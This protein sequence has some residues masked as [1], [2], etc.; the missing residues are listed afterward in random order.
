MDDPRWL[1]CDV[2]VHEDHNRARNIVVARHR[3]AVSAGRL[4]SK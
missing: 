3:R 4:E 2:Y 1:N